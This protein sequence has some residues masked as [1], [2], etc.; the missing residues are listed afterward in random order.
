M[1][2]LFSRKTAEVNTLNDDINYDLDISPVPDSE[3]NEFQELSL[4]ECFAVI[5]ERLD[6]IEAKIDKIK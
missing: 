2:K 4:N 6:N 5:L 3:Y 1:F